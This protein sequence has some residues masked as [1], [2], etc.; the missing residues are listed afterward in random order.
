MTKI[1]DPY[2]CLFVHKW[3]RAIREVLLLFKVLLE[4]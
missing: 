3:V 2:L 4:I 1:M